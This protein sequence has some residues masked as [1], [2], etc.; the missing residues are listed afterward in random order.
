VTEKT[1]RPNLTTLRHAG[2]RSLLD[3]FR[4]Y[5]TTV[6]VDPDGDLRLVCARCR[7]ESLI[8]AHWLSDPAYVLGVLL[9][10]HDTHRHGGRR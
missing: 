4:K 6:E 9:F 7:V 1:T 2:A 10:S 8:P 3:A 5:Y